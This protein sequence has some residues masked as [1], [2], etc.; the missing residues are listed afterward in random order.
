VGEHRVARLADLPGDRGLVV[1]AAG[2]RLGLFRTAQGDVHAYLN[3][4]PRQGGPVGA[5]GL[6]PAVRAVVRDRRLR[7]YHDPEAVVIACP[8]HGWEFDVRT[9]RCLADPARGLKRYAVSVRDGDIYVDIPGVTADD[10]EHE[11]QEVER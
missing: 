1:D 2:R 7:E 6:F 3:V 9:G 5:G 11:R 10:H 4:C 8:W